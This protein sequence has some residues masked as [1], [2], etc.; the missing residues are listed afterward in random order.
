MSQNSLS[1]SRTC[2]ASMS[3]AYTSFSNRMTAKNS[4]SSGVTLSA[5]DV[6]VN[7]PNRASMLSTHTNSSSD[8]MTTK[9][10]MLSTYTDSMDQRNAKDS[11]SRLDDTNVNAAVLSKPNPSRPPSDTRRIIAMSNDSDCL[12]NDSDAT[13]PIT[14]DNVEECG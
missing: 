3:P 2:K 10:S 7:G 11:Y 12:S 9:A 6:N 14:K 4:Y 8:R 13:M 1:K 5:N